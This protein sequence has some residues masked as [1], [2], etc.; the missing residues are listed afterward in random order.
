MPTTVEI[1]G[2]TATLRDPG[3]PT[4]RDKRRQQVLQMRIASDPEFMAA[5]RREADGGAG[6]P[7]GGLALADRTL[8]AL[9]RTTEIRVLTLL[10]S[11]TID[12]PIPQWFDDLDTLPLD[13]YDPIADAADKLAEKSLAAAPKDDDGKP[14]DP[15]EHVEDPSHAS[16][17]GAS[18]GS[19][20]SSAVAK[21]RAPSDRKKPAGSKRASTVP[22]SVAS[23]TTSS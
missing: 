8:D 21:R 11:W 7:V 22:R 3:R 13:I 12:R 4:V 6:E 23:P 1:P 17:T 20:V 16:P 14:V 9:G 5:L 10:E 18:A 19:S 15:F 2:G